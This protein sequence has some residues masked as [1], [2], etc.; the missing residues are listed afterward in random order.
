MEHALA[1]ALGRPSEEQHRKKLPGKA[2]LAIVAGAMVVIAAALLWW[3]HARHFEDTDDAQ[4]DA[5]ITAVSSRVAGTVTAV[6]V[7]DNQE[8]RQGQLL[9]ELDPA[10]LRTGLAQA[11]AAAEQAEANAKLA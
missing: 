11:Q 8:V 2:R 3:L 4:I 1:L 6:H 10:D 9:I 7:Q 5:D